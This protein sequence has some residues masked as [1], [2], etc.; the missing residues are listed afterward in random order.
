[1]IRATFKSL[2]NFSFIVL[3]LIRVGRNFG[4]RL[5]EKQYNEESGAIH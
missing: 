5:G 2:D 4:S 1:M 3:T